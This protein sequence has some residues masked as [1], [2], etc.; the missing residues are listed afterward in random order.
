MAGNEE[1]RKSKERQL[2]IINMHA[3]NDDTEETSKGGTGMQTG[4]A[5][6]GKPNNSGSIPFSH[7]GLNLVHK[8]R[9]NEA[10][11]SGRGRTAKR[12]GHGQG[13]RS[14]GLQIANNKG[15][16]CRGKESPCG[17]CG[18]HQS[19][20]DQSYRAEGYKTRNYA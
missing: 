18:E 8:G 14:Q 17:R 13:D 20:Q 16:L 11:K 7:D 2:D 9:V 4:V 19:K 6:A 10:E 1:P 15:K 3:R 5:R 12:D